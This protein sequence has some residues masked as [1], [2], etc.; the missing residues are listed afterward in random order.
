[1]MKTDLQTIALRLDVLIM[2]LADLAKAL[3]AQEA[4]RAADDITRGVT[5]RI[6]GQPIRESAD[7]TIAADLARILNALRQRVQ[8][9]DF[10]Q[11]T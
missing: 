6:A 9:S 4:A 7:V 3:P 5:S 2:I 1:M 11:T 8:P 10:A